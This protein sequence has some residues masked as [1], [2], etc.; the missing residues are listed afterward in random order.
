MTHD[1]SATSTAGV[2]PEQS[3]RETASPGVLTAAHASHAEAIADP[4]SCPVCAASGAAESRDLAIERP[5]AMPAYVYSIGKVEARYPRLSV[6]KEFAQVAGRIDTDGLTDDEVFHTVLHDPENRHLARLLCW[7]LTVREI[8]T[9][10]LIPRDFADYALLVEA[11][12]P[13]PTPLDLDVVIGA[14]GPVASPDVCNGLMVPL[15][16]FNQIYS[17]DRTSLISAIPRDDSTSDE[18]FEAA[19]TTVLNTILQLV[20]NAGSTDEHRALNYLAMRYPEIYR[21]T[22]QQFDTG[23]ALSGVR[24]QRSELGGARNVVDCVFSYTERSSG[25]VEKFVAS[26]DVSDEFPFLASRLAGYYD[27]HGV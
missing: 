18:R 24:V 14:R 27:R 25:F 23:F 1:A 21:K 5:P 9:Y 3:A 26:V 13:Q 7:V 4:G 20:D 11:I 15:V 17:F 6:E 22:A 12:R 10:I 2:V 8:E 19:A 16:A